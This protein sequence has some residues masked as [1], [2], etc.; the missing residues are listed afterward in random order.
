MT[1]TDAARYARVSTLLTDYAVHIDAREQRAWAELFLPDGVLEFGRRRTVGHEALEEFAAAS[2]P[3]IHL[4]GAPTIRESGDRLTVRSQFIFTPA[5]GTPGVS[6][7]YVDVIVD[8]GE[9][10]RFVHRTITIVSPARP[11]R[12]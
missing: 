1:T 10:A 12:G 6:G 11:E 8:D 3:G 4:G 9:R 2:P 7:S 5:D